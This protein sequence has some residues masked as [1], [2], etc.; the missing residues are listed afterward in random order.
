MRALTIPAGFREPSASAYVL[1]C[2]PGRARAADQR[3]RK[4]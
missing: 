1:N 2:G 3:T 4:P